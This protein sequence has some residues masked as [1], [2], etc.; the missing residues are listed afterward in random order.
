[1]LGFAEKTLLPTELSASL[2]G[3]FVG[4]DAVNGIKTL[5]GVRSEDG[6]G[7]Q[8]LQVHVQCSCVVGL[9]LTQAHLNYPQRA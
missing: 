6:F 1:M 3:P 8:N 9:T 2:T 4:M 5:L 7:L